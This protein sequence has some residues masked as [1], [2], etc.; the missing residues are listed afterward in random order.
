MRMKNLF[1]RHGFLVVGLVLALLGIAFFYSRSTSPLFSNR[2]KAETH[3]DIVTAS[4]S[5]TPPIA[6]ASNNR[7]TAN[8]PP[9]LVTVSPSSEE[10]EDATISVPSDR[11]RFVGIDSPMQRRAGQDDVD[12]RKTSA[13]LRDY[14]LAFKQNPVGNNAEITRA[15]S[16]K[17]SRGTRYLPPDAHINDKGQ[18]TD[19]WDQPV[20]FHQISSALMEVRSAGPDRIM[21]T[22]DDEVL[23]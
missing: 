17:N 15:L 22:A 12:L 16:G 11:P 19:H 23:R 21:W 4:P 10:G 9:R 5:S 20:F 14:R 1:S 6:R 18:L 3:S 7:S 2:E 8:P 13:S